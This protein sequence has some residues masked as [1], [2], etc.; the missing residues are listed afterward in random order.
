MSGEIYTNTWTRPIELKNINVI[1]TTV[2]GVAGFS[3]QAFCVYGVGTN[4]SPMLSTSATVATI[5]GTV[6]NTMNT[7]IIIPPGGSF[8]LTNISTGAGNF[9]TISGG[10]IIIY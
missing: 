5:D 4:Y 6:T 1:G 7:S 10:R 3:Q 2:S 8:T 9:S